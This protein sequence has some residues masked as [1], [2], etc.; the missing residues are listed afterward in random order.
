MIQENEGNVAS[1]PGLSHYNRVMGTTRVVNRRGFLSRH[2]R[3]TPCPTHR[4]NPHHPESRL[5][6]PALRNLCT[7]SPLG[8]SSF[9]ERLGH[10]F[11]RLNPPAFSRFA[12]G[13]WRGQVALRMAP[14]RVDSA[15]RFS[16]EYKGL[17]RPWPAFRGR[18]R[19]FGERASSESG[20]CAKPS[21]PATRTLLGSAASWASEVHSARAEFKRWQSRLAPSESS[22]NRSI[23]DAKR[24]TGDRSSG[25]SF[26]LT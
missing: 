7:Y 2:S 19:R 6:Q 22:D 8:R 15:G 14:A 9:P 23:E 12:V 21:D 11:R 17:T 5:P 20:P 26:P 25:Q 18:D 16:P 4:D 3:V 13:G 10:R 1:R 24:S